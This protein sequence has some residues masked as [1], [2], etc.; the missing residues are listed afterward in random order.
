M[1][2]SLHPHI[3]TYTHTHGHTHRDTHTRDRGGGGRGREKE[4]MPVL[5]LL[6]GNTVHDCSL[7]SH[8]ASFPKACLETILIHL[9][10]VCGASSQGSGSLAAA[11]PFYP[12]ESAFPANLLMTPLE[13]M[14]RAFLCDLREGD[15]YPSQS[16]LCKWHFKDLC[17]V[18][19]I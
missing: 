15:I 7:V 18:G 9:D 17:H 8:L 14:R 13:P 16:P 6:R 5:N 11:F 4:R 3:C 2:S 1:S 19:I 10:S 12:E